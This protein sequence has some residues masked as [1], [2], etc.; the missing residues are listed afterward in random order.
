MANHLIK[1][2]RNPMANEWQSLN[3]EAIS[4]YRK[5]QY[6]NAVTMAEKAL[7]AAQRTMGPEHPSVAMSLNN[8]ATFY[9]A[10]G[11][12]AQAEPLHKRSLEIYKKA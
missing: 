2:K 12:Y 3:Q 6:C 11:Q 5:G 4:F 1:C 7:Q 10:Q 8:L 9:Y